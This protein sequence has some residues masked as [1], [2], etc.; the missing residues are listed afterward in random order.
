MADVRTG[1][2]AADKGYQ[3]KPHRAAALHFDSALPFPGSLWDTKDGRLARRYFHKPRSDDAVPPAC[4]RACLDTQKHS[5]A[6]KR[7][8]EFKLHCVLG[9]ESSTTR[10]AA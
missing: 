10:L 9:Y 2:S 8:P 6:H 7:D 3:A 1:Q 5:T 4:E